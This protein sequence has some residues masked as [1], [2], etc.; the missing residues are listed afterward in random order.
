MNAELASRVDAA[1]TIIRRAGKLALDYF[2]APDRLQV[3]HKGPQD[4]VSEADREVERLIRDELDRRF[5]RDR[6]L[7]E[8]TGLVEPADA[9]FA[10]PRER[11]HPVV[12][13]RGRGAVLERVSDRYRMV[14]LREAIDDLVCHCSMHQQPPE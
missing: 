13:A 3:E 5:P 12:C 1:D 9:T 7:G 10:P 6:F 8:E 11:R 4:R 14:G 2:R